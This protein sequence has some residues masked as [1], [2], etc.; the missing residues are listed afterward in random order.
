M[1]FKTVSKKAIIL[2]A[3]VFSFVEAADAALTSQQRSV[4][5]AAI[6]VKGIQG[7]SA[8]WSEHR[9]YYCSRWARQVVQQAIPQSAAL[10]RAQLFGATAIET[11]SKW[12]RSGL[13]RS[14][15]FI[16]ANGGLRAGDLLFQ[17]MGS[18]GYGHMGVVVNTRTGLQ[19]AENTTRY[20]R[21][22]DYR[23]FTPISRFGTITGVGRIS[24]FYR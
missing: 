15:A 18:G 3:T 21:R 10:V 22:Y 14:Y 6:N 8:N 13:V 17:E 23:A 7:V 24:G 11:A 12:R 5:P 2:T 16:Q 4:A 19:V 9:P 20:G 1:G